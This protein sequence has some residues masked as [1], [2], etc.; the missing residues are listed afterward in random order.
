[1]IHT[2]LFGSSGLEDVLFTKGVNGGVWKVE[3]LLDGDDIQRVLQI[4]KGPLVGKW[5]HADAS[6]SSVSNQSR[7]SNSRR[8]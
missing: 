4:P 3:L 7:C 6:L 5:V 2:L 8:C 1:V